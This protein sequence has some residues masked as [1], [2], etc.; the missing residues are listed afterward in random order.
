MSRVKPK[1]FII[2][3]IPILRIVDC[4]WTCFRRPCGSGCRKICRPQLPP[5]LQRTSGGS[6]AILQDRYS[7]CKKGFPK[8]PEQSPHLSDTSG[9]IHSI[10]SERDSINH[11]DSKICRPQ[12]FAHLQRTPC[13]SAAILSNCYCCWQK[14]FSK[15][16]EQSPNLQW[17]SGWIYPILSGGPCYWQIPKQSPHLQH[18]PG[19][20]HSLLSNR[21]SGFIHFASQLKSKYLCSKFLTDLC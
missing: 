18:T 15:I 9:R 8:I 14:G 1:Y 2:H 20:I 4:C 21:D 7:C 13:R 16:P 17:T 3:I 10:L 19:W 12:H 11:R 6:A 5:N